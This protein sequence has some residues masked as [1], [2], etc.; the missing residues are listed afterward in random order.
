MTI[1]YDWTHSILSAHWCINKLFFKVW[2]VKY[3]SSLGTFRVQRLLGKWSRPISIYFI[4]IVCFWTILFLTVDTW[5]WLKW[6]RNASCYDNKI[7][8]NI[9]SLIFGWGIANT[10]FEI[11][12]FRTQYF[13]RNL[14]NNKCSN[15][16]NSSHKNIYIPF[17]FDFIRS[18]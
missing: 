3:P 9:F 15:I 5:G 7:F 6:S 8:P 12:L 17:C 18:Q 4:V 2:K 11:W 14:R 10:T 16:S 13:W 1:M